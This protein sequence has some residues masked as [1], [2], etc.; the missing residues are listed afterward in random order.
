MRPRSPTP[1]FVCQNP[2]C[3][4]YLRAD[5]KDI[6]RRGRN[7]AGRQMLQCRHCGSRFVE[8]RGTPAFHKRLSRIEIAKICRQLAGG[9][10]IRSIA[11]GTGRHR[12]TLRRLLGAF[13]RDCHAGTGYLVSVLKFNR[14]EVEA[15]WGV[16]AEMRK[17]PGKLQ[18]KEVAQDDEVK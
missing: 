18:D 11:R 7:S 3:G 4:Y 2:H 10:G 6:I 12:E 9:E 16:V 5:G 14:P 1:G 8:T 13:F 17:R 15:F